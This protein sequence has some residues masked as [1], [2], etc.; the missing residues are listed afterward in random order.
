MS[1]K[2]QLQWGG[3]FANYSSCALLRRHDRDT[4]DRSE[5]PQHAPIQGDFAPMAPHNVA[6]DGEAEPCAFLVLVPCGIEAV[7]G[8]E[9]VLALVGGDA[10]T[11]IFD[12]D[13]KPSA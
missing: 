4:N 6:R 12:N 3:A 5:P 11:I 8:A 9:H 10:G 13:G 1:P 2:G 7:E